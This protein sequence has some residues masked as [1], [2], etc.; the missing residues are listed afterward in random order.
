MPS[1]LDLG[2]GHMAYRRASLIDLYL[3]TEFH[4]NRRNFCGR[5]VIRQIRPKILPALD[6]ERCAKNGW[7]PELKFSTFLADGI[8]IKI[9]ASKFLVILETVTKHYRGQ[10][11][12]WPGRFLLLYFALQ[13]FYL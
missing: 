1:N 12:G 7:I 2:S 8:P 11:L 4:S 10:F 5:T 13:N 6:L 3:H 9:L